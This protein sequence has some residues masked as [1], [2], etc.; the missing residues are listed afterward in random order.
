M[1]HILQTKTKPKR[2]TDEQIAKRILAHLM[3]HKKRG[4]MWVPIEEFYKLDERPPRVYRM[5]NRLNEKLLVIDRSK[6]QR[7]VALHSKEL[8]Q[9]VKT[10]M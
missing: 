10:R 5:L 9:H 2:Q 4:Q 3:M 8:E 1:V 7:L 6:V